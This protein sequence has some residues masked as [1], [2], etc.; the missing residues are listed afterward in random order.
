MEWEVYL[1]DSVKEGKIRELY[2]RK[3]P[4]LNSC[5]NWKDIQPIGWIDHQMKYSHY[6]GALVKLHDRIYFI[7]EKTIN[8]LSPYIKFKIPLVI[9]VIKEE[10]TAGR[11]ESQKKS[12]T[13]RQPKK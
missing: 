5:D 4:T 12:Q 9:E 1:K 7:R 6:K 3:I 13:K 8:A 10:E 2:L 11:P